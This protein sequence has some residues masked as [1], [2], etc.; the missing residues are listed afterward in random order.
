MDASGPTEPTEPAEPEPTE[1]TDP[2][3][4]A[5]DRRPARIVTLAERPDLEDALDR[6]NGS[7]WPEFMLQDPVADE[8]WHHLHADF[9]GWQLILLGADDAIL[10]AAN[11]APLA[12]DGTD[13]GL[14]DGW[15]D[16]FRRTVAQHAAGIR[17]D[18]LGAIQI[19]VA[20]KRRG[21]RLAG[22]MVTEMR[23]RARAAGLRALI[24]CVRPTDKHRYPL[25][26]IQRYAR[27]TRPDGEPFDPWIRLHARLGARIV[28]GAPRSMTIT[29]TVAD[30][31]RWTSMAFPESGRYVVPFATHPVEIDLEAGCGVYHDA[32][33]WMVHD[34]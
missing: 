7:A 23:E 24:A 4:S 29:G 10:A 34:L 12:W 30:W 22:R 6:H 31:E 19:V 1:P 28:R 27:W 17:P 21:D 2:P 13:D 26:S 5:P 8:L 32:N 11:C 15:D 33:V 25:A 16:Q 18:T 20:P 14:P 9:A 3:P